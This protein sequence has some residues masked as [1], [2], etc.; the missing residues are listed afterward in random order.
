MAFITLY[1]GITAGLYLYYY[2]QLLLLFLLQKR[3]P[4]AEKK[5]QSAT[6]PRYSLKIIVVSIMLFGIVNY[7]LFAVFVSKN[8]Q[9]IIHVIN[10]V[11]ADLM[12]QQQMESYSNK[13][14]HY[15]I[16]YPSHWAFYQ[17]KENTVTFYNNN[18]GTINGGTWLTI[19]VTPFA[20]SQF[21]QYYQA[22]P[23]VVLYEMDTK[24]VT[25]KITNLSLQGYSGVQYISLKTGIP[26]NHYEKHFIVHKS[27]F[28]YEIVFATLT[29]ETTD[30]ESALIDKIF[31]SFKF[32][33]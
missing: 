5:Q 31:N 27:D 23:G 15:T 10:N 8:Y 2:M 21:T 3:Q 26:Y 1:L 19:M 6:K 7:F 25:T 14:Y 30:N 18:T 11:Y 32:I 13:Q 17:W 12:N 28:V 24:N 20:T 16:A 9:P 33:Q 4:I 29:N 22:S